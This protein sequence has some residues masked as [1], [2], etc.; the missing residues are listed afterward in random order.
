MI[1]L[2]S[3]AKAAF[4]LPWR[5]RRGALQLAVL[6]LPLLLLGDAFALA[7]ADSPPPL[8]NEQSREHSAVAG[9]DEGSKAGSVLPAS[10]PFS[11]QGSGSAEYVSMPDARIPHGV[12][13]LG[14]LLMEGGEPMAAIEV[15]GT[16]GALF[17]EEGSVVQVLPATS[18]TSDGSESEPLYIQINRITPDEVEVSPRTRPED[19][20]ILR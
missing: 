8:E 6:S 14:V 3:Y 2:W 13:L 17:V 19:R 16:E 18:K 1:S 12:R 20:R 7:A 15:P 4:D 10:D 9:A 11:Y 5:V